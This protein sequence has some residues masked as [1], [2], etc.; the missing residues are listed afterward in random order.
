MKVIITICVWVLFIHG[1]AAIG[2]GSY[3]MWYQN[4]GNLTQLNA[5]AYAIG[6]TNLL[7]AAI[8]AKLRNGME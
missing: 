7:M 4:D 1:L 2:W 3:D 5:I 8:A 6:T